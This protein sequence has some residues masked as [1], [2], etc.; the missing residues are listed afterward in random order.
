MN[1][2]IFVTNATDQV[3]T[4]TKE[5]GL[6][7]SKSEDVD[8]IFTRTLSCTG[9]SA[10]ESSPIQ[11]YELP[12]RTDTI[13]NL[14]LNIIKYAKQRWN[15]CQFIYS[16]SKKEYQVKDVSI[17]HYGGI[18][19]RLIIGACPVPR[20]IT[21]YPMSNKGFVR[22]QTRTVLSRLINDHKVTR[23]MS[24]MA[25]CDEDGDENSLFRPYAKL[26]LPIIDPSKTVQF[27]K[28]GIRD[29]N[30]T[31][32]IDILKFAIKIV[33]LLEAGE[34]VYLHC[35]GGHGRA[36]TVFCL[37]LHLIYGMNAKNALDFCQRVHDSRESFIIV[38]S[39]QT[40]TQADQVRHIIDGLIN[41]DP[42]FKD[43][44][45]NPEF[46]E[47]VNDPKNRERADLISKH[48]GKLEN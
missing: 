3:D 13:P 45:K 4:V 25:E 28:L 32:N 46:E 43:F 2:T 7:E 18:K 27:D 14:N 33:K 17:A 9:G 21:M 10:S 24:L 38:A 41:G 12:S 40:L 6:F 48:I 29:C 35:W 19:D 34:K 16:A 44:I 8:H 1:N 37:V 47:F 5:T 26:D 36:G 39:P 42:E 22:D 23:I 20:K 15:Q 31:N 30:V 11:M